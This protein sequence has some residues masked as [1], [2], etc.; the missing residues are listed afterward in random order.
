MTL[1]SGVPAFSEAVAEVLNGEADPDREL[2]R[3]MVFRFGRAVSR[4]FF[5][6]LNE[7]KDV[8][9]TTRPRSTSC[10]ASRVSAGATSSTVPVQRGL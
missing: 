10:C 9:S 6:P 4:K 7:G 2:N 3:T 8:D 1:A 5:M